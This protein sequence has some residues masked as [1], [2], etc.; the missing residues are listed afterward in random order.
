MNNAFIAMDAAKKKGGVGG[1]VLQM[2]W[3]A[4]PGGGLSPASTRSRSIRHDLPATCG[5]SR[6]Y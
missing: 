4:R 3:A 6:A 1:W 5:W 2:G